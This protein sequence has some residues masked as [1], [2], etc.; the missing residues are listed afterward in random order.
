M[1]VDDD[2]TSMVILPHH[3]LFELDGRLMLRS[4]PRARRA[5]GPRWSR[6]RP[7]AVVMDVHLADGDWIN[8]LRHCAPI[9]SSALP[10]IMTSGM[11]LEDQCMDA[12][13]S[14]FILKPFP[15]GSDVI[16]HGRP[17]ESALIEASDCDPQPVDIA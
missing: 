10:V 6:P 17:S 3:T 1:L 16:N 13:A 14:A 9:A 5:G 7:D 15:P 8:L 4:W 11:D 12:G 2:R